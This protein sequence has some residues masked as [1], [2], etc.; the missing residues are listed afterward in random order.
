MFQAGVEA[1]EAEEHAKFL[2]LTIGE[3]SLQAMIQSKQQSRKQQMD[4]F[5]SDI[6]AKYTELDETEQKRKSKPKSKPKSK[7]KSKKK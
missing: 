7:S 3:G 4:S 1:T 5:F 2:G 6:E